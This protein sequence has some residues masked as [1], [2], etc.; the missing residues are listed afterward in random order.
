MSKPEQWEENTTIDMIHACE[1]LSLGVINAFYQ[2]VELARNKGLDLEDLAIFLQVSSD[3][4]MSRLNIPLKE[5]VKNG[6]S[7]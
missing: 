1:G 4:K 6:T 7:H 2:I 3:R 5:E